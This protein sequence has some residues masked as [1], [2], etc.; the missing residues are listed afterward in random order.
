[1][2]LGLLR[3]YAEDIE[4]DL[5]FR[6]ID[7]FD[8]YQGKISNRRMLLLIRKLPVDSAFKTALRGDWNIDQYLSAATVNELRAMRAD[9]WMIHRKAALAYE[10]VES[11][12]VQQQRE[13]ER[14]KV[15]AAHDHIGGMLRG[16]R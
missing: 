14:A 5:L 3:E 6:G 10:W 4:A 2:I 9:L 12:R 11:P 15:R 16:K 7:I 1:M 8:W 13:K